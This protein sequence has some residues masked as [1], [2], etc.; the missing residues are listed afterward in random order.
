MPGAPSGGVIKM[1]SRAILL[2]A[3]S[4]AALSRAGGAGPIGDPGSKPKLITTVFPLAEIARAVA[5]DR[6][7]IE[8][9]LPP[10]AEVHTW[11]PRFS[12]VRKLAAADAFVLIGSGLEPWA[13]D[14]LR[15]AA[16]PGLRV[17][18]IGRG[19]P[20]AALSGRAEDEH[21]HG[22]QGTDPHLWLDFE[23]DRAVV[24]S[25][26]GLLG[27]IAPD[28]AS[29]FRTRAEA[30]KS[31]LS[32]LDEE[33]RSGLGD[34]A[35]RKLIFCGHSAFGYLARRYRLEV[36]SVYGASPDAAPTPKAL[37]A[38]IESARA[39][40]VRTIFFEPGVGEK[41][42][43]LIADQAGADVR[44]LLPGHN[45]TP[46]ERSAGRTFLDLMRTNLESLRHGLAC[47]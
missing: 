4:I 14:L 28:G 44:P 2:A 35:A 32:K 25:I 5:G 11:Q 17:L 34:C 31:A 36:Q 18:E 7:E 13:G 33:F 19:L 15:G 47:R 27:A 3:L 41:L 37:A 16:K 24:D 1:K 20:L 45:L 8:L 21:E 38:V 29:V 42:A 22:G 9:L 26:A 39:S 23:M 46:D 10:G 30:Y 12:D 6:V 43:R 40:R